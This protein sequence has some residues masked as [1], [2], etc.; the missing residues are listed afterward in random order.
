VIVLDR[1]IS[2]G[3]TRP[4]HHRYTPRMADRLARGFYHREVVTVARALLGQRLVRVVGGQRLSGVIV[5]VEAYL[6]VPD[7]AAHTHGGRHTPRNASMWGPGGHAYV[8]F[9]YGMHHCM[10]VVAGRAGQ[11]VAALLRALEPQEGI[12]VMRG[13]RAKAARDT[14]LCSGPAKLCQ[15]MAI[16]RRLDGCDL[17][18]GP[19]LF[20]ESVRHRAHR[21]TRIA[22]TPRI[23]VAYA[24][25]WAAKPLRFYLKD[26]PHVSRP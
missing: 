8:Y 21:S 13:L 3:M 23:G 1:W 7:R 25:D 14:D 16:D 4:A 19:D 10:N 11:P 15:A 20:I 6:G 26:N 9:T 12:D 24:G 5:E 17:V 22:V 18:T 2:D